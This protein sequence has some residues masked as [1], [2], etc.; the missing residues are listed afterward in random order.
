MSP[1]MSGKRQ[2]W[3][4]AMVLNKGKGRGLSAGRKTRLEIPLEWGAVRGYGGLRV[5]GKH[6]GG[7]LE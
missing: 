2:D 7:S 1:P 6:W 3:E 5:S 4:A